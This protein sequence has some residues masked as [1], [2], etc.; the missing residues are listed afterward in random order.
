MTLSPTDASQG[1]LSSQGHN[2]SQSHL[3]ELP[4]QGQGSTHNSIPCDQQP[5]S[6][7]QQQQSGSGDKPSFHVF[8]IVT[9]TS[10]SGTSKRLAQ[11]SVSSMNDELF[12]SWVR[13]MYYTHRGFFPTWLGVYRYSHCA[14]FKVLRPEFV[15][16]AKLLVSQTLTSW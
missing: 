7:Q 10:F 13:S 8:L 6:P 15:S 4:A 1:I 14:F 11:T 3:N 5:G 12:F 9:H 16:R 2:P